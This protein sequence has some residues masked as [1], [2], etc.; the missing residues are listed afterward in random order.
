LIQPIGFVRNRINRSPFSPSRNTLSQPPQPFDPATLVWHFAIDF[1]KMSDPNG[2]PFVFTFPTADV[3]LE[4]MI[5]DNDGNEVEGNVFKFQLHKLFLS[6]HSEVFRTLFTLPQ[7]PQ[8]SA[9]PS[10]DHLSPVLSVSGPDGLPIVKLHDHWE[11]LNDLLIY[12]YAL[13]SLYPPDMGFERFKA[14]IALATK[15]G[16]EAVEKKLK[17]VFVAQFVTARPLEIFWFSCRYGYKDEAKKAAR[18]CIGLPG[19][20]EGQCTAE[21][22]W[23]CSAV[24]FQ[25]LLRYRAEAIAELK[26]LSSSYGFTSSHNYSFKQE[27]DPP[28]TAA[29]SYPRVWTKWN[30]SDAPNQP[31]HYSPTWLAGFHEKALA[32]PQVALTPSHLSEAEFITSFITT[33]PHISAC[34]TCVKHAI[35]LPKFARLHVIPEIE[36]ALGKVSIASHSS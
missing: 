12:C 27:T 32:D 30:Y 13:E 18:L 2:K 34:A 29:H 26:K 10:P 24:F 15:Y 1:F 7:P 21:D 11:P 14:A 28:C 3:V 20:I 16:F 36:L 35:D 5:L 17:D 31:N 25:A 23:H 19:L 33:H 4:A 6:Q 22:M 9:H 8:V